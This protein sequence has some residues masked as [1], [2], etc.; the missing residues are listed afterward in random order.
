MVNFVT[1]LK[2]EIVRL[3]R[4][5]LRIETEGL[6]KA[7]AQYRS[8][9]AALKRKVAQLEKQV[10]RLEKTNAKTTAEVID[11]PEVKSSARF[12]SKGFVTLRKRLGLSAAD[13]GKL[14]GVSAQTIYSWE[15][16]SSS[17][18]AQQLAKIVILRG[19]GKKEVDALLLEHAG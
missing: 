2:E 9:I 1:V 15:A 7:S 12:T 4:K 18:R 14:I 6:K 16:G 10:S 13:A 3:A 17:P 5:E 8:D 11:E 19:M